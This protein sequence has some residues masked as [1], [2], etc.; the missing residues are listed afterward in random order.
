MSWNF[1]KRIKIA[2]GFYL[3]M[4]KNGMSTSIGPKGIKLNFSSRGA[5][6][7]TSIPG[8]GI[9]NRT[10]ISQNHNNMNTEANKNSGCRYGCGT[11]SLLFFLLGVITYWLPQDES[12]KADD[13]YFIGL[14]FILI[15]TLVLFLPEIIKLIKSLYKKEN[16]TT[17]IDYD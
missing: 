3:N 2:P 5:Y 13:N 16:T 9:Y 4:S 8:T 17:T 12:L 15:I 6:L 10:K 14:G 1:R 7:N 11:L